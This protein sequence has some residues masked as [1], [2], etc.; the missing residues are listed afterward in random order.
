[1]EGRISIEQNFDVMLHSDVCYIYIYII[2]TRDWTER[3]GLVLLVSSKGSIHDNLTMFV[4]YL[5]KSVLIILGSCKRIRLLHHQGV[6]IPEMCGF[7]LT[8]EIM[9]Y[10]LR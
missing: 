10:Y 4:I 2:W 8:V 5:C 7:F 3:N 1:M 9:V 6:A